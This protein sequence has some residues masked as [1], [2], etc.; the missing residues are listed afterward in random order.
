MSETSS[1]ALEVK[2]MT[3]L[4]IFGADHLL[5]DARRLAATTLGDAHIDVVELNA[6]DR[7]NFLF[8]DLSGWPV[9]EW[10]AFVAMDERGLNL[11]RTQLV[12]ELKGKGYKLHKLVAPDAVIGAG[13]SLGENTFV[14]NRCV[15]G[16]DSSL[17]LN[18]FLGVGV[19]LGRNCSFGKS[20]Y[21]CDG[22]I[23]EDSVT[24]SDFATIG[25]GA[26]IK[27]GAKIGRS[28]ELRHR[29]IYSGEVPEKT[30][31]IDVFSNAVSIIAPM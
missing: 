26:V 19:Q 21:A 31:Y 1:R 12:A 20:A 11:S 3:K 29:K 7:F 23:M 13:V 22:A 4:V 15:V 14:G 2:T 6:P 18:A 10:R 30:F 27:M 25:S 8:P 28:S 16:A 5:E 9:S 24:I 17:A